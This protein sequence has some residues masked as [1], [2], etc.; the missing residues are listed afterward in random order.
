MISKGFDFQKLRLV[1]ILNADSMLNYPDFRAEERAYQQITQVGGRAGRSQIKGKVLIQTN[2]PT[3]PVF[4]DIISNNY[5][6]LYSRL[7]AERS[8]FLYPPFAR[9]I[10]I[11][12]KHKNP[13]QLER[14]AD[15]LA[16]ILRKSFGAGVLGPEYPLISRIQTLYIKEIMLKISRNHYGSA[17]KKLSTKP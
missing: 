7:I 14:D 13:E 9:L 11:Q 4:Q 15:R 5:M 12:L 17:A 3:H 10:K 8:K 1:A 2:N 6:L 16:D